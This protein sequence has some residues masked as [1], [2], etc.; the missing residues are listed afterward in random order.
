MSKCLDM[1]Q[2]LLDKIKTTDYVKELRF[3]EA[4]KHWQDSLERF[5]P[6]SC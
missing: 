5:L 1:E 4:R 6:A 3:Q 2:P